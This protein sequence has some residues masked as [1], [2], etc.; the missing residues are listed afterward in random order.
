MC[1][2]YIYIVKGQ[3]TDAVASDS[4]INAEKSAEFY[5]V[6]VDKYRA[7]SRSGKAAQKQQHNRS[8]DG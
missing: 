4:K 7:L 6:A 8:K 2:Q 3:L 5:A 1:S